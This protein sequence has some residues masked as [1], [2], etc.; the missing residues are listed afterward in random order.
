M[1]LSL[2]RRHLASLERGSNEYLAYLAEIG[3]D[4]AALKEP[5]R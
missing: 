5:A 1:S 4:P 3:T 2:S